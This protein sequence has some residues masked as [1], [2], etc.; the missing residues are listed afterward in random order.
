MHWTSRHPVMTWGI[1]W[2]ALGLCLKTAG[3]FEEPPSGPGWVV[4]LA[5]T[6]GWAVAGSTTVHA[7]GAEVT[8][9]RLI[10]S[11]AVWGAA[12]V[13]LA[14]FALPLSAWMR[15]TRFGSVIPPGFLGM[16]IA[17][18][19][20]AAL[21]VGVTSRLVK[22]EPGVIRPMAVGVR[23]GFFFFIGG[24]LG[25]MLASI[26]AQTSVAMF[27]GLLGTSLAFTTGWTLASVLAGLLASSAALTLGGVAE[28]RN[29]RATDRA[30]PGHNRRATDLPAPPR[31][32]AK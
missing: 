25:V 18:S 31:V 5:G 12:F 19:F 15:Q 8:R 16:V 32:V 22:V 29:R 21:A 23:W 13:W 14:S 10:I 2:G 28:R 11:A 30:L 9:R 3:V 6:I 20:A 4:F 26:L 1:V 17:W 7:L 24:Y 27:G